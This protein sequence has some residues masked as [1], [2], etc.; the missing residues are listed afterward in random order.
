MPAS[1]AG[2]KCSARI[3]SKGAIPNGVSHSMKNGFVSVF[4]SAG[5]WARPGSAIAT[6]ARATMLLLM[7]FLPE[8]REPGRATPLRADPASYAVARSAVVVREGVGR[9]RNRSC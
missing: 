3:F 6:V 2:R 4:A 1:K 8:S 7:R 5:G 9:L